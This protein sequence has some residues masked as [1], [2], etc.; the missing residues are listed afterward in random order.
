[1][2]D[3]FGRAQTAYFWYDIAEEDLY[4]WLDMTD[5]PVE[6]GAVVLN[7]GDALWVNAPDE[8]YSIQSAGQV[9]QKNVSVA[10]REGNKLIVNQTPVAVDLTDISIEGYE[11]ICEGDV[12]V[13]MLDKFGRAQTAYFWYDIVEED[14]Y[15]WLDMTDEPVEPETVVI[16]AG[17][18]LWVNAPS[19]DY[20][21]IV[22]GV[23]LL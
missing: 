2:L 16:G 23:T 10:L 15:G 19:S 5:E 6:K 12:S 1:M 3:K 21:I 20:A 13:Q 17:E 9:P 8:S 11:E 22:P 14:L 7:A 18:T 4:G